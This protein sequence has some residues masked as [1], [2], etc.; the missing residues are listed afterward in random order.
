MSSERPNDGNSS[1]QPERAEV[2]AWVRQKGSRFLQ[3]EALW[4]ELGYRSERTFRRA[5]KEGLVPV[6][7][8]PRP[9]G[10]GVCART[11]DVAVWVLRK[12]QDKGGDR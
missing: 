10:R 5:V 1:D 4:R 11:E 7:L 2:L 9:V 3:G 8:Y 6:P 12:Q